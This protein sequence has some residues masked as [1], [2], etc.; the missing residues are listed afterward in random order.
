MVAPVARLG[1]LVAQSTADGT[2]VRTVLEPFLA[3]AF[4]EECVFR[5]PLL[6]HARASDIP[7][8]RRARWWAASLVLYVVSHAL[9]AVLVRPAARGVFDAPAFLLGAALRDASATLPYERTGSLWP[10]V[11]LHGALVAAWLDLGGASLLAC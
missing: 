3:P 7:A 2:G 11:L 8:Q 6:P 9:A 1:G 10:G 5:G 4:I